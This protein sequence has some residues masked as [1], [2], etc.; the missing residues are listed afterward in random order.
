MKPS[1][2]AVTLSVG[3]L[4]PTTAPLSSSN[5]RA[6][7]MFACEIHIELVRFQDLLERSAGKEGCKWGHRWP[8]AA[9]LT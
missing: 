1:K 2:G 7:D 8:L 6:H 5:G 4:Q 3:H 9:M